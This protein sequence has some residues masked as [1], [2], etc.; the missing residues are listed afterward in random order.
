MPDGPAYTTFLATL[1][2]CTSND[3]TTA[4]GGFAG[5]CDWRLPTS[6]ELQTLLLAPFSCG[7]HP[8][9]D[10]TIFGPTQTNYWSSTPTGD[11]FNVWLVG[12]FDGSV[13]M[14]DTTLNGYARAVRGG[15]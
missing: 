6:A 7:T 9:I 12:F 11:P 10:Q 15:P 4:S 1:N 2:N 13:F 5:H 14:H 3:G 8:C